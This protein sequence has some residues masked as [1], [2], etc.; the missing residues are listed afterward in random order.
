MRIVTWLTLAAITLASASN[1]RAAE[2][3]IT[4][5]LTC[6]EQ[7]TVIAWT[8]TRCDATTLPCWIF[9]YGGASSET[10][11]TSLPGSPTVQL[12]ASWTPTISAPTR[13]K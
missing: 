11:R 9:I 3:Y 13:C 6:Q 5:H 4:L 1:A 2:C 12:G 10:R 7:A 8:S